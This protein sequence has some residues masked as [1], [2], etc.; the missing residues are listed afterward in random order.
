M[1]APDLFRPAPLAPPNPRLPMQL[2][3]APP[4]RGMGMVG[5]DPFTTPDP[6]GSAMGEGADRLRGL[7]REEALHRYVADL[8]RLVEENRGPGIVPLM[9]AGILFGAMSGLA[10]AFG[11]AVIAWLS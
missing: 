2:Y 9:A 8:E 4:T 6:E 1:T 10:F 11:E 5:R 3:G 7:A